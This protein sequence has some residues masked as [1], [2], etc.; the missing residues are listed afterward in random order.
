[1]KKYPKEKFNILAAAAVG[2]ALGTAVNFA[3]LPY[4]P[5]HSKAPVPA[6]AQK[7]PGLKYPG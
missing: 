2:T 3:V 6:P 5:K 4:I 1:M 7:N